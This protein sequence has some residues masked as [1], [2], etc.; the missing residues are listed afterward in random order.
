MAYT[1]PRQFASSKK[2]AKMLIVT[3]SVHIVFSLPY[4]VFYV[5][6]SSILVS[7]QFEHHDTLYKA[8][9]SANTWL[10]LFV[11]MNSITN[12]VIY[13]GLDLAFQAFCRR[14]FCCAKSRRQQQSEAIELT[15]YRN[16]NDGNVFGCEC[17]TQPCSCNRRRSTNFSLCTLR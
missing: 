16:V 5:A 3:F 13:G 17:A 6:A 14:V 1:C 2:T 8:L 10:S 4:N 7:V 11:V 9:S 12:C 15:T